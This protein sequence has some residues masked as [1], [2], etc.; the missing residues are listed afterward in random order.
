M[1]LESLVEDR[2]RYW[3]TQEKLQLGA[4]KKLLLFIP[5]PKVLHSIQQIVTEYI[6]GV[7]YYLSPY[8]IY[9]IMI[10]NKICLWFNSHFHVFNHQCL[11]NLKITPTFSEPKWKFPGNLWRE[12]RHFLWIK[13]GFMTLFFFTCHVGVLEKWLHMR[14]SQRCLS[15][16]QKSNVYI[17]SSCRW[18]WMP[19]CSS[20]PPPQQL[21]WHVSKGR[22]WMCGWARRDAAENV[23]F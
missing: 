7:N 13:N 8:N 15:W 2:V 12:Y 18:C 19:Q 23:Q 21:P 14:G 3:K 5:L 4:S 10:H 6:T 1:S 20:F 17:T 16:D 11:F 22:R 9:S